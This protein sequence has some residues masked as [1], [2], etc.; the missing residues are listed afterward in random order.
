MESLAFGEGGGEDQIPRRISDEP[1]GVEGEVLPGRQ[2]VGPVRNG[3][4]LIRSD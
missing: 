2:G 3:G 4:I 1:Q